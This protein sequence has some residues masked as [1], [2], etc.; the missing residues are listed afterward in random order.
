MRAFAGRLA[1]TAASTGLEEPTLAVFGVPELF[2]AGYRPRAT[3]SVPTPRAA[4]QRE[5]TEVPV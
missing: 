1:R 2:A 4:A 5:S 3:A